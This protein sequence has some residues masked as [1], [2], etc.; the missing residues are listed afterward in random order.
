MILPIIAL[1]IFGTMFGSFLSVINYRI[2]KN[3]KGIFFGRSKCPYCHKNLKAYQ[4]IPIISY[5]VGGGKC[6]F[7]K[8]KISITYP[9]L[10]LAGGLTLVSLFIYEPFIKL[11]FS[12]IQYFALPSLL[13]FL[14]LSFIGFC[15]IGIFFYD[16]QYLEIP[17]IYTFPAIAL[18]FL[19]GIF[20]T[21]L[22]LYD[23]AIG[24]ALAGI[25]FGIQVLISKEKWLGA[26]D[27]QLGIL[28][29]LF[30]GWKL[31][32]LALFIIYFIGLIITLILMATK[33]VKRTSKIPFAPFLIMGSFITLFFGK[34]ILNFYINTFL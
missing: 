26:G 15:F 34:S 3:E 29:G 22:S 18:V 33:K 20:G 8:K 23:S 10:E 16:I 19:W 9:L 17:E 1:F 7:C 21:T 12:G 30:F 25:F 13:Y 27:L 24:G 5:F 28:I 31:F 14:Y 2:R 4:L 11:T 32:L 6:M